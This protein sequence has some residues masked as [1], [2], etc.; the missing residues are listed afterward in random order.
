MSHGSAPQDLLRTTVKTTS[1]LVGA[2]VVFVGTLSLVAVLVTERAV[3]ANHTP[4]AEAT[5]TNAAAPPPPKPL[6]I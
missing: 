6:S 1:L 5:A 4:R 3:G 2:C